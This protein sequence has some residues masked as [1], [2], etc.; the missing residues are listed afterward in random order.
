MYKII[1]ENSVSDCDVKHF[2]NRFVVKYTEFYTELSNKKFIIWLP[3]VHII[4]LIIVHSRKYSTLT[5]TFIDGIP[6]FGRSV[7]YGAC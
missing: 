3:F 4:G 5:E 1:N 7:C 6:I 2:K